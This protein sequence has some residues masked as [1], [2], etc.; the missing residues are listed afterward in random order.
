M[1]CCL[2]GICYE[3]GKGVE[4]NLEQAVKFYTAA[5]ELGLS[6]AQFNLGD[7][8]SLVYIVDK[9]TVSVVQPIVIGKEWELKRT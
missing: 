9:I 6:K 3:K 5:A 4:E 2:E 1:V 8:F 7:L